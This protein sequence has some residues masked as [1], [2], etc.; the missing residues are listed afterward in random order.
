MCLVEG[1]SGQSKADTALLLKK[2]SGELVS[3]LVYV[4][5]LLIASPYLHEVECVKDLLHSR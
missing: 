3:V 5:G 4:D 1:G 2:V